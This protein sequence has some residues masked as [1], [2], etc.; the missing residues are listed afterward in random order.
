MRIKES[1][2]S[3]SDETVW[4]LGFLKHNTLKSSCPKQRR[5][6]QSK[7]TGAISYL[8]Y[9]EI[10]QKRVMGEEK[11]STFKI[12]FYVK[13]SF[14]QKAEESNRIKSVIFATSCEQLN[15]SI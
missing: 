1:S 5:D 9:S 13:F 8:Q 15:L 2:F 11:K 3:K 10:K 4:F 14:Y 7:D 6:L 12:L